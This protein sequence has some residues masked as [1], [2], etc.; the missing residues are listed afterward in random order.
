GV[1]PLGAALP[2]SSLLPLA[3]LQRL[4]GGVARRHPRLLEGASHINM[5]EAALIRQLVL[6]AV[7]WAGP[8]AASE[9]V[10]TNS[11]TEALGLCLRAVT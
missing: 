8:L 4:Y 3:A 11:C 5:D 6:R 1:A 2:A 10:I 7:G 9:F